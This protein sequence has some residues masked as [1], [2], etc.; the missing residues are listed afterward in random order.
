MGMCIALIV[1]GLAGLSLGA[2]MTVEGAIHLG[3]Q[4]GL[5]PGVI[6]L[7][8]MAFGTS[9]PELVTCVV[10]ALKGCCRRGGSGAPV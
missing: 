7:T 3:Q 4:I 9:L 1:I 5:S 2:K 8:I 6:G 10:A